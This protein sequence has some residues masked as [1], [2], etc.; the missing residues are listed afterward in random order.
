MTANNYVYSAFLNMWSKPR[1]GNN[2]LS[3]FSMYAFQ[4]PLSEASFIFNFY[5]PVTYPN[6]LVLYVVKTLTAIVCFVIQNLI[7]TVKF[8]LC[9]PYWESILT[10]ASS[11]N[12]I[13]CVFMAF[14]VAHSVWIFAVS[15]S[16]WRRSA[17]DSQ[18]W[19]GFAVRIYQL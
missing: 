18:P 15:R 5:S 9:G 11:R 19:N 3:L 6:V 7:S 10:L 12:A 1:P 2:T 8:S 4:E 14:F 13:N 16:R 17:E